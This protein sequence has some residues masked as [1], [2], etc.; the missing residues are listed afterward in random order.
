[1]IRFLT[2][3]VAFGMAAIVSPL[4]KARA[5]DPVRIGILG[6]DNYQAVEYVQMYNNP[7]AEGDFAG[8]RVTAAYPVTSPDYPKSAELTE[9]WKAQMLSINKVPGDPVI[10]QVEMVTSIDELL[11]RC[12]AVMIFSLDSR[13]HLAQATAVL[14]AGK[15]LYIG[16]PL[17]STP[18]D[19]IAIFKV[20]EETKVP[21]WSC[22]QH[23]FSPGFF[24]MRDHAEVGKVLG[25]DVYG[26][27]D[28]KAAE[29]DK[30]TRGL[31]SI[32][33]LYTIMGPGVVKVSCTSTPTVESITAVWAD[34]RVGTFRGIKEGAVKY[35][36]TVFG[37]KGVSTAGIY[38]HGIPVNG[39]VP[40]NDKYMGYGGLAIQ[41]AKFFKGGPV[42]VTPAETLEIHSL[43]VAADASRAQNGVVVP[44]QKLTTAK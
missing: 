8:L 29:A 14:K 23:R 21:C 25:C 16:R 3:F 33:T 9:M 30:S 1:M 34:G 22:S 2:L 31:H 7:K 26:G 6:I 11:K 43:F 20:S 27:F 40:T 42:P 39:I 15:P 13:M 24:G 19:A 18:E 28:V 32:E 44:L 37:D 35:S 36:A 10:P 38:G 12:D 41:M 4:G 17:A 5:A